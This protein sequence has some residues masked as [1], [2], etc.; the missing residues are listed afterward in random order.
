MPDTIQALVVIIIMRFNTYGVLKGQG[1][2]G[3]F[4]RR[5]TR[6]TGVIVALTV[7]LV[8]TACVWSP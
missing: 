1:Q 8:D 2:G 7:P 6:V 5:M 3:R 4:V